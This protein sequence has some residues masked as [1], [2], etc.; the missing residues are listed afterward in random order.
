MKASSR[1]LLVCRRDRHTSARLKAYY[2]H[3]VFAA[4]AFQAMSVAEKERPVAIL[5]DLSLP[6]VDGSG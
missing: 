4:D 6:G 1:Q 3:P 5:L 2:Y